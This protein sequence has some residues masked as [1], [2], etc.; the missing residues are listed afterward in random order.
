MAEAG[1]PI[2]GVWQMPPD[3]KGQVGHVRVVPCGNAFCGT[4]IRAI[5]PNGQEVMTPN[6]GRRVM[7]DMKAK[8]NG[9]YDD[10]RIY[11]PARKRQFNA[12]MMLQGPRMVLRA[13]LGPICEKQILQ[14]VK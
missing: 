10:G 3:A 5:A 4:V 9:H 6:V 12:D 8:G 1:D 2:E 13:C 7:W 14:R 11:V